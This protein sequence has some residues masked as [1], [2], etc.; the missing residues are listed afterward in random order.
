MLTC[1]NATS[2]TMGNLFTKTGP[3][4][5]NPDVVSK[6][7]PVL[8]LDGF[9]DDW[10]YIAGVN[11]VIDDIKA[12]FKIS[13][14]KIY[15]NVNTTWPEL[16][17]NEIHGIVRYDSAGTWFQ[18]K[19][20]VP[21]VIFVIACENRKTKSN[22]F[23]ISESVLLNEAT[24]SRN[25]VGY[26]SLKC[27]LL[28]RT[29]IYH[30]RYQRIEYTGSQ[31]VVTILINRFL[32]DESTD[33]KHASS[34]FHRSR[35]N[36][37]TAS[38]SLSEDSRLQFIVSN[39]MA[40]GRPPPMPV[41]NDGPYV[42][43]SSGSYKRILPH[44][45]HMD[46]VIS[47]ESGEEGKPNNFVHPHGVP[48]RHLPPVSPPIVSDLLPMPVHRSN[49]NDSLVGYQSLIPGG[50][51]INCYLSYDEGEVASAPQ[52]YLMGADEPSAPPPSY[53]DIFGL[54]HR[55]CHQSPN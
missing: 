31:D 21:R 39:M 16:V 13:D 51:N 8:Y 36:R 49:V 54:H 44:M 12:A 27:T 33:D 40:N 52:A 29:S 28:P 25:L 35:N 2:L 26:I 10:S 32:K 24:I 34:N 23:V 6:Y 37:V 3:S 41:G 5:P 48:Y 43:D 1:Y 22:T 55:N 9:M 19:S 4:I 50:P 30:N 14:L 20:D 18:W 45:A 47:N 11:K 15:C 17:D 42:P 38:S 7:T 46:A 53:D